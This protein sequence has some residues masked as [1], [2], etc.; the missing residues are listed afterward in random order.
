MLWLPADA[1]HTSVGALGQ[2][3]RMILLP[4]A[5]HAIQCPSSWTAI[6]L[7]RTRL[8]RVHPPQPQ[9]LL[10]LA[11]GARLTTDS[12]S[13]PLCRNRAKE[14]ARYALHTR[15]RSGGCTSTWNVPDPSYGT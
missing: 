12:E 9:E 14:C 13:P 5:L 15:S 10:P 6:Y 11:S 8:F 2:A 3:P 7:K 1:R 4:M